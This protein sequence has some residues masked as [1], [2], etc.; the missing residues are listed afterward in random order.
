MYAHCTIFLMRI[1]IVSRSYIMRRA[2]AISLLLKIALLPSL[3]FFVMMREEQ[4][5]ISSGHSH[6]QA[7]SSHPFNFTL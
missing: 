3:I 2:C 5:Y 7:N 6:T 1:E 4:G